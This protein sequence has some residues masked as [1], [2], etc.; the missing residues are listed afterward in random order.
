MR[1]VCDIYQPVLDGLWP[2]LDGMTT[3]TYIVMQMGICK[4]IWLRKHCRWKWEEFEE[5]K[6]QLV[7]RGW[8]GRYK[9]IS[10][11]LEAHTQQDSEGREGWCGVEMLIGGWPKHQL[12][13]S[14]LG[15]P[16]VV[17]GCR[18]SNRSRYVNKR[19]VKRVYSKPRDNVWYTNVMRLGKLRSLCRVSWIHSIGIHDRSFTTI[20][21]LGALNCKLFT[22]NSAVL[23]VHFRWQGLFPTPLPHLSLP[24]NTCVSSPKYFECF[25]GR[26][27]RLKTG[28]WHSPIWQ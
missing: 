6:C 20:D 26:W 19:T 16:N 18:K 11:F 8:T 21:F 1:I 4:S 28:K 15:Y 27:A 5:G 17:L 12:L 7:K 3:P 14:P 10:C 23:Y 9:N 25:C 22:F 13:L 2:M 24:F